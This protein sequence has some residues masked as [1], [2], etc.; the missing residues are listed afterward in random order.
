MFQ[1]VDDHIRG[2][3]TTRPSTGDRGRRRSAGALEVEERV[4]KPMKENTLIIVC[5]IQAAEHVA[6]TTLWLV[7]H[8]HLLYA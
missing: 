4:M 7:L 6:C 2:P 5:R 3:G 8:E 1:A